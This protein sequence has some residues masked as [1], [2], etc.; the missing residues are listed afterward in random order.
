M[1]TSLAAVPAGVASTSEPFVELADEAPRTVI[2]DAAH[3]WLTDRPDG[4]DSDA[5]DALLPVSPVEAVKAAP[6]VEKAR[7]TTRS[8][9]ASAVRSTRARV[10]RVPRLPRRAI[11]PLRRPRTRPTAWMSADGAGD[12]SAPGEHGRRRRTP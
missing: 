10:I 6:V 4:G 1:R 11:A 2:G 9:R 12:L 5:V 7:G 8:G 3:V